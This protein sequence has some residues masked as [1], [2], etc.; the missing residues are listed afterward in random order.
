MQHSDEKIYTILL[1]IKET[2][3]EMKAHVEG[4][5][6]QL[7]KLNGQVAKNSSWIENWKGRIAIIALVG[8]FVVPA[9]INLLIGR[10]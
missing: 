5:K 7:I 3:G 8:G 6:H 1:D 4:V 2:Q 10:L 9:I